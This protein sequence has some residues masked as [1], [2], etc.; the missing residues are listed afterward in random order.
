MIYNLSNIT[1][2]SILY[3]TNQIA[4]KLST[5]YEGYFIFI[6]QNLYQKI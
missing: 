1:I 4:S 2:I 6:E 5:S 3:E